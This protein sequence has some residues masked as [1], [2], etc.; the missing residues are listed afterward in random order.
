MHTHTHTFLH[1]SIWSKG[2]EERIR[3]I[4]TERWGQSA[5]T[6]LIEEM[7]IGVH[8]KGMIII[9]VLKRDSQPL[10]SNCRIYFEDRKPES[11]K[12]LFKTFSMICS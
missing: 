3:F 6:G 11:L 2:I 9:E 1:G 7:K 8:L 10:V 12:T 5:Q 4:D